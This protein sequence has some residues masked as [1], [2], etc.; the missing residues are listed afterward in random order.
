MT[1]ASSGLSHRMEEVGRISK[2]V[3]PICERHPL[4][5]RLYLFGSRAR[6]TFHPS[7]DYDLY[8]ELDYGQM[9]STSEYLAVI[10]DLQAVL[11][12]HVDFI[13]GDIWNARDIQLKREIDRDG[14]LLYDRD[15]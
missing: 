11:R 13:S 9:A 4:I 2:L 14:E 1:T 10:D 7:S 12:G 3:S 6:G 5:V 8:A 15:A